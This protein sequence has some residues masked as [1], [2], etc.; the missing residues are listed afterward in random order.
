MNR[1]N[2]L[3]SIANTISDY[4]LGEIPPM[5]TSHVDRWVSQ[6]DDDEQLIILS[7][8]DHLLSKYYISKS[9]IFFYI[10]Q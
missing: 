1:Q 7:E 8:M 4:R 10:K 9:F 3:E 5:T 2:L 6:F